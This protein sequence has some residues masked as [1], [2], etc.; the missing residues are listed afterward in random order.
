M[1][2]LVNSIYLLRKVT[3]GSVFCLCSPKGNTAAAVPGIIPCL[4]LA[5]LTNYAHIPRDAHSSV[6]EA[7]FSVIF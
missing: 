5:A 7:N 6:T 3:E 4:D 2:G 1:H